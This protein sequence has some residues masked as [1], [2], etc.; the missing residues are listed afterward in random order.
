ME[1][2]LA[3]AVPDRFN[4]ARIPERKPLN[5]RGDLGL[6]SGVPEIVQPTR[7]GIGPARIHTISIV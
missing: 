4:V 3:D 6:R 7:E 5:P 1:A 2:Q